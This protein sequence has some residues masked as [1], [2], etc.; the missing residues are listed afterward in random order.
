LLITPGVFCQPDPSR[1]LKGK[2]LYEK[3]CARC[4][5]LDGKGDRSDIQ[6]DV[7]LPNFARCAEASEE[8][9]DQWRV[10]IEKGGP[11]YGMSAQMP[12]Y[13]DVLTAEQIYSL[14]VYMREFCGNRRW[15]RGEMN[16]QRPLFTEKAYPENEIVVAPRV[17]RGK[18][19]GITFTWLNLVE[20]RLGPTTQVEF[21]L[22]FRSVDTE[23]RAMSAGDL[24]IG[25]K[26]VLFH[27]L[28]KRFL[29]SAGM[30]VALP[31]GNTKRG[32]GSGTT[33]FEPFVAL[34]KETNGWIAQGNFKVELPADRRESGREFGYSTA[35][36]RPFFLCGGVRDFFAMLEV[37]GSREF[38]AGSTHEIF[39]VPQ[40]RIPID[41]LGRWAVAL[42]PVVPLSHRSSARTGFAAYLLYEYMEK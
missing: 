40:V 28:P 5:G 39:M 41:R 15:V 6:L 10:V 12:A 17:E 9:D 32:L 19:S 20:R 37:V 7:P 30:D 2:E 35:L 34:G 29:V 8:P 42:G 24:E 38:S 14:L 11:I 4:H 25:V 21:A 33:K 22:P 1:N 36:G 13:G 23:G 26:Q 18:E 16:F 3:A 27:S 31:T